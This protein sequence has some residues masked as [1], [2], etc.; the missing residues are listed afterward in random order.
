M[1]DIKQNM[2]VDAK[3]GLVTFAPARGLNHEIHIIYMAEVEIRKCIHKSIIENAVR[4]GIQ[5]P[6]LLIKC[7]ANV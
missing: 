7:Y 2:Y 3:A 4:K 1:H 5:S 6:E